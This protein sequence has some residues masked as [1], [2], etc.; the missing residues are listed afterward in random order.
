MAAPGRA[1]DDLRVGVILPHFR[2]DAGLALAVA[3]EAE[4]QGLDG[5]FC[6]DH[7]WPL[8]QPGRPA[9]APFPLLGAV[10]ASTRSVC[11]G[12]LV[13]RVGL[14]PNEVLVAEFEALA[15]LAP[16]RVI[17]GLGTG[18]HLSVAENR[19]YGLADMAAGERREMLR[20][21]AA[22]LRDHGFPVWVGGGAPATQAVAAAVGVALNLWQADAETVAARARECE[23]TWAGTPPSRRR[24]AT[25][26]GRLESRVGH[27]ERM[28]QRAGEE[29]A[30]LLASLA[31]AGA[32]WAVFGP[33][34]P[35]GA[36]V[37]ARAASR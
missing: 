18:D 10:A 23:V 36:L 6:Y 8:S 2:D 9:L 33:A 4:E 13:A 21:C 3:H 25:R 1:P 31:R 30:S 19:A 20:D 32:T 12:T 26:P 15:S 7:L 11:V 27:E 34:P 22:E 35:L 16:G 29:L 37:T 14:V 17:A 28:V 24:P 5:V